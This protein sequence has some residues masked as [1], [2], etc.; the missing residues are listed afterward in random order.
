MMALESRA[1]EVEDLGRQILVHGRKIGVAE[2]CGKVADVTAEDVRR[3][4]AR[5]F[6]SA[7][8]GPPTIV[9]MG[10]EDVGDWSR[11]FRKYGVGSR[12]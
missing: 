4:A 8:S 2:M 9:V 10:K 7:A 6:G 5:V 11:T 1:V 12:K 3:V